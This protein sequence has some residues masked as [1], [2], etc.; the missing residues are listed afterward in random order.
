[1]L[2]KHF[3]DYRKVLVCFAGGFAVVYEALDS[4]EKP[5][6]IKVNKVCVQ[7]FAMFVLCTIY[8]YNV[9]SVFFQKGRSMYNN[10]LK[11]IEICLL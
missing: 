1:M 2:V 6:A 7:L 8:C 5:V 4:N 3:C 9:K 11:K 10:M